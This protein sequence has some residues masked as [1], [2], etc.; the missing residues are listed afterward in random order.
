VL[1]DVGQDAKVKCI[2]EHPGFDQICLGKWS[3]RMASDKYKTKSKAK[4]YQ[5]NSESENKLVYLKC[6]L[7]I[8]FKN[9]WSASHITHGLI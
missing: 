1:N 7:F 2:T 9:K 5:L 3:L 6:I 8:Y 4:Y